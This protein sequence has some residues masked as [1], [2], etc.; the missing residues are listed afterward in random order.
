[1]RGLGRPVRNSEEPYLACV[2][3]ART[4]YE[5]QVDLAFGER[6]ARDEKI[7][8]NWKGRVGREDGKKKS[9]STR[10]GLIFSE[11]H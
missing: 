1:M 4:W 3:T 6:M 8:L 10:Q 2:V 9:S 7:G 11:G 5:S